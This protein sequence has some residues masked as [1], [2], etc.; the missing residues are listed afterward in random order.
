M[1]RRHFLQISGA[2]LG[3]LVAVSAAGST[4][5]AETVE[6]PTQVFVRLDEGMQALASK[7]RLTWTYRDIVVQ[8]TPQAGGGLQVAVQS[9]KA[10]LQAVQLGWKYAQSATVAVLGDA[11]ERSY[12]ELQFKPAA[13]ARWLPWYF[14]Q[15][16]PKSGRTVCFGVKTGCRTLCHW[17]VGGGTM[18]LTLDTSSGG[19]GV[20]LGTRTL[21]AA[22]VLATTSEPG[23]NAFATARRFCGL[24]CTAPRLPRQPVYGVNDWYFA[25]G[26]NNNALILEHSALLAELAPSGD[27]RPFSVIDSGWAAY[28]PVPS[29]DCCWPEDFSKPNAK[30]PDMHKLAD[31]IKHMGVRPGLWMR[32]L[33]ARHDDNPNRFLPSIPGRDR[34]T[35]PA[36]DP[37]IDENLDRIRQ[38]FATFQAWGYEMVKHDFSTYDLLGKWGF[39]ITNQ[40]TA[41]G[42]RF[43]DNSRTTAEIMLTLYQ[44]IREAAGSMYLIGCNT[45]GHLAAGLFELSRIGD[46]T[47]GQ[48]WDI[49]RKMGVNTLGF[50]LVQHNKFFA[51]DADCACITTKVPWA[52]TEQWLR[53]LAG[54]GTPLFVSAQPAAMG[55]P[56]KLA[57]KNAFAQAA[58]VQP[59]GEPLDWLTSLWPTKWRLDGQLT[60]F[61]W[62]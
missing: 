58:R 48:K 37:T 6:L 55:A 49:T 31:D 8:L 12:G 9:P 56:Q 42:W 1:N 46:D 34:P 33:T 23:E 29:K 61:D 45:V 38:N 11:W 51:V 32:P 57:L 19:V 41:P 15:Y 24:M 17:Q 4:P 3:S 40:L 60:E 27:N 20:Q 26:E 30:F 52:E 28:S 21:D 62:S 5:R 47:S 36:L 13:L 43:H 16:D 22:T 39:E 10:A 59:L 18:Q 53:L 7:N 44:T 14:V 54:S 50:R 35:E 25:Y 2:A